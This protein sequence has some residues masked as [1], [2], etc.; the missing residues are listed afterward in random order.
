M[1][2]CNDSDHAVFASKTFSQKELDQYFHYTY[3]SFDWIFL[4]DTY[5]SVKE[6]LLSK[7]SFYWLHGEMLN[8]KSRR[9]HY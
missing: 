2:E 5:Q 9:S 1:T 6:N 4:P 8:Q 7:S 3:L